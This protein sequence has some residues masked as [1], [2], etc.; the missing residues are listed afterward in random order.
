MYKAIKFSE[1]FAEYI[2]FTIYNNLTYIITDAMSI[3]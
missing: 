2:A 1:L 3:K